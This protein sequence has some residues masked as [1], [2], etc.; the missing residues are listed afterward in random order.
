MAT[1][2]PKPDA[3]RNRAA[4]REQAISHRV[5]I[6]GRVGRPPRPPVPLGDAGQRW[7]KWAWSTPQ[8]TTWHKGYLEPLGRRAQLEDELAGFDVLDERDKASARA[9]LLPIMLRFDERFALTPEAA[10]KHHLV[11]VDEPQAPKALEGNGAGHDKVT[12]IRSRLK[13][14]REE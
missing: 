9:R 10:L 6:T 3:R 14:M 1:A 8:A 7:W 13:G 4:T 5:P 12:P 11:F 2:I